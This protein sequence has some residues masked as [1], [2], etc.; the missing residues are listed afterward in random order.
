[1]ITE[2]E[3]ILLGN[4]WI[5]PVPAATNVNK[6]IPVTIQKDR[7]TVRHGDFYSG[8]YKRQCIREFENSRDQSEICERLF[9]EIRQ[10]DVVQKEFNIS[11]VVNDC[12]YKKCQ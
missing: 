11:A 2:A 1:M 3:V 7:E 5:A 9:I 10:T 6:D 4:G 12:N 8:N